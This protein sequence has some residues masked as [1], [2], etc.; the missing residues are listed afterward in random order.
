MNPSVSL[1]PTVDHILGISEFEINCTGV[2]PLA[3]TVVSTSPSVASI[4]LEVRLNEVTFCGSGAGP[5]TGDI[6]V[7]FF[8]TESC[9]FGNY[10]LQVEVFDAFGARLKLEVRLVS[11]F[12]SLCVRADIL[13]WL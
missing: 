8:T 7:T 6:E 1:A 9:G 12:L 10:T 4:G 13:N 5:A 11:A 3:T 2:L